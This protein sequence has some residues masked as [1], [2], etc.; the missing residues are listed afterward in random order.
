MKYVREKGVTREETDEFAA[1]SHTRTS[2]SVEN[3]IWQQ[4]IVEVNG[5]GFEDEDHVVPGCTKESLAELRTAFGPDSLVTAGNAS[6]VV[7][8]AAA[9]VVKSA[10]RAEK[11]GDEPLAKIIS[12]GIVGLEP[13][14]MA[15][16]PV[17]SSKLALEKAGLTIE[18]IDRWEIN[19]KHRRSSRSLYQRSWFRCRKSECKRWCC[20]SWTPL[21][22]NRYSLSTN[23]GS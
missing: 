7:D 8:G 1:L 2:K 20:R 11:D 23:I 3:G 19:V 16:G 13:A 5:I 6:G 9:V 18:D 21:G 14:I 15:Y 12:W 10:I 22:S 4:E 17:P